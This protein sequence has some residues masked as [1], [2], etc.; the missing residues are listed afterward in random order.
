MA[1]NKIKE[2]ENLGISLRLTS[3]GAEMLSGILGEG[4]PVKMDCN[5]PV[6]VSC[7]Y[8]WKNKNLKYYNCKKCWKSY[9][10]SFVMK[11]DK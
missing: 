3:D 1:K 8:T 7:P 5:Y 10:D 4:C 6:P 9:L 2:L 11:E